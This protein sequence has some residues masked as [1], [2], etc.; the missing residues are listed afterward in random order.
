V[1]KPLDPGARQ[2][3]VMPGPLRPESLQAE[4][5]VIQVEERG[6]PRCQVWLDRRG[7]GIHADNAA[8]IHVLNLRVT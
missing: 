3:E 4:A 1:V 6:V 7:V 5:K 8:A 2:I